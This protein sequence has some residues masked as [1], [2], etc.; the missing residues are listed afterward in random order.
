MKGTLI[1]ASNFSEDLAAAAEK[2][3]AS[4]VT[5]RARS[6][7]PSS[8]IYWRKGVIVTAEHTIRREE[9]ISIIVGED[10]KVSAKLAGRDPGTDVAI[11]KIEDGTGLKIPQFADASSLKLGHFVLALGRTRTGSLAA[12]AGIIG[13]LG[14]AHRTWRGGQVDQSIRLSL[15]LYPGFSGGPL[16]NTEGQ[17]IGMNTGIGHGRPVTIPSSTVN[18]V[19]DELLAKGYIARPYLGVAMQPVSL[20]ESQHEKLKTP[21]GLMVMH[22]ESDGPADKAGIVL[23]DVIVELQGKFAT[24]IRNLMDSVSSARVGD[25]VNL[26]IVR[27]GDLKELTLKLGERPAR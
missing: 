25:S 23:G 1:M 9:E 10:K 16:L 14:P 15:E 18:R 2:A 4:V 24:D 22:V 26:K 21:G 13:A 7:V 5:V 6:R 3:G 17:V 11:L 19:V 8:G 12:S 20:P 27:A